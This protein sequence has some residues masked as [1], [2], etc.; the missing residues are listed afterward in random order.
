[1]KPISRSQGS[2]MHRNDVAGRKCR[3]T[4]SETQK[5]GNE[6]M[7]KIVWAYRRVEE[8]NAKKNGFQNRPHAC[9][10]RLQRE[11]LFSKIF[12]GRMGS[13]NLAFP[14]AKDN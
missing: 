1:M 3:A 13:T 7:I 14:L 11:F 6:W 12:P 9:G 4:C 10:Y 8:D 2:T 5:L